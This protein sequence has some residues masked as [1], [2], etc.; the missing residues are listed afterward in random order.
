MDPRARAG[1]AAGRSSRA[2]GPAARPLHEEGGRRGGITVSTGPFYASG[3]SITGCTNCGR[4]G[5]PGRGRAPRSCSPS[6]WPASMRSIASRWRPGGNRRG[7]LK[8]ASWKTPRWLT[9]AALRN[10]KDRCGP[11]PSGGIPP[12]WP[13]PR[14]PR[15][16]PAGSWAGPRPRQP[17]ATAHATCH[18]ATQSWT[19][20]MMSAGTSSGGSAPPARTFPGRCRRTI[21]LTS[22]MSNSAPSWRGAVPNA[23]QPAGRYRWTCRTTAICRRPHKV[24]PRIRGHNMPGEDSCPQLPDTA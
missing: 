6:A 5:S 24:L 7:I 16:P 13:G 21:T 12:S 17:R 4:S 8:F 9:A 3:P 10:R 18:I 1:T 23:K 2:E 22:P 15:W 19:R 11:N 20:P 14:P